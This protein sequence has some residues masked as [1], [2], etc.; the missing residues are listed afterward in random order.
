MLT[1]ERQYSS[2]RP[3][4]PLIYKELIF[5]ITHNNYEEPTVDFNLE[6]VNLVCVCVYLW[7]ICEY[8]SEPNECSAY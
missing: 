8:W 3:S 4:Y 2:H 5:S 6:G 1:A 7:L